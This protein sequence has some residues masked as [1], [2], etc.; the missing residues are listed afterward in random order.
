MPGPNV[1][2]PM[3]SSG[4]PLPIPETCPSG[5][6]ISFAVRARARGTLSA[7]Q[8]GNTSGHYPWS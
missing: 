3:I 1:A 6:D 2:A 4:A 7:R 5:E 8:N